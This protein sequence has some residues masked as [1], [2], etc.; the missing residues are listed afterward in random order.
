MQ[1]RFNIFFFSLVFS[2]A[3]TNIYAQPENNGQV[4]SPDFF[5][6]K[7]FW[8]NTDYPLS[9]ET[10][11]NKVLIVAVIDDRSVESEYFLDRLRN[12]VLRQP[13][14]QIVSVIKGDPKAPVSRNHLV[15]YIQKHGF[16]HPIGVLPDL[17]GFRNA[18]IE[19]TPYFLMYEKSNIPSIHGAGNIGFNQLM[20]RVQ[21]LVEDK[22]LLQSCML[23]QFRS[24]MEP[25]WWAN[26][27]IETPTYV[28]TEEGGEKVYINDAAHKRLLVIDE[29]GECEMMIGSMLPGYADEGVYT[30]KF[31]HPH[32]LVHSNGK[33]FIAD[34]YNNRIRVV[35]FAKENVSTLTGNGY[36]SWTKVKSI[37]SKFEPL[38]LPVDLAV[39]GN[40]LYVASA[41]SNQIFEVDMNDGAARLFCDLPEEI[42]GLLRNVPVNLNSG[43]GMLYLTM[44]DGKA[45]EIDKKGKL[46][47]VDK[48]NSFAFASVLPWKGGLAGITRD[49]KV[50]FKSEEKDWKVLGEDAGKD[51]SKNT[52]KLNHPTDAANRG[53]DLLITDTDNHMLREL[54]SPS[55]KMVKNY[56]MKPN[57]IL[58]GFEPAHT[59][60]EIV[61]MDTIFVSGKDVGMHV[62]LDLEG[63]KIAPEGQNE[64][65]LHDVTGKARLDSEVIKKEEFV[66]FVNSDYPD[67]DLYL[68]VYLTIEHPENPGLFLIK[69]A[70]LDF[71]VSKTDVA[72]VVQEQIYKPSLLPY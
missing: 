39:L 37:D 60:G 43:N 50:V 24:V 66:V 44:A 55:D 41:G 14:F 62:I 34:T 19:T 6:E 9:M 15:Q 10:M 21:F 59:G 3:A 1:N 69:R 16:Q 56:W 63:Y 17:S 61:L 57:Q 51:K 47:P 20:K 18:I 45:F 31:N 11:K 33:L 54:G 13:G 8:L 28:A 4:I 22:T 71:P 58:V 29:Q 12:E 49:G 64:L 53:S 70:Y 67:M 35:D 30:S 25:G 26:P 27:V 72:D 23:H 46:N 7:T 38:G 68:E 32:G 40:S 42:V 65:V 5:P 36:D 52:I 2:I 48:K